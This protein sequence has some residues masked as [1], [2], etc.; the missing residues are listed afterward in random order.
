MRGKN[1]IKKLDYFLVVL[2]VGLVLAVGAIS[3]LADTVNVTVTITEPVTEPVV[4]EVS[5]CGNGVIEAGEE[6]DD[7]NFINDDG[8]SSICTTDEEEAIEEEE[9]IIEEEI[10]EEVVPPIEEVV[11]IY[12]LKLI[13]SSDK[14]TARA[15]GIDKIQ[16]VVNVKDFNNNPVSG[17]RIKLKSNQTQDVIYPN[18]YTSS[19]KGNAFFSITSDTPHTSLVQGYPVNINQ[20]NSNPLHLIFGEEEPILTVLLG[21]RDDPTIKSIT[22]NVVTPLSVAGLLLVS[23][24]ITVSLVSSLASLWYL[25]SHLINLLLQW[26]GLKK[27]EKAW[28]LVYNST[29]KEPVDLA[30]VRLFDT[31]TNKVKQTA[32]TDKNGRFSFQP[33]AGR[34]YINATKP[35]FSFPSKLVKGLSSDSKYTKLYF[36]KNIKVEER[37][38]LNFSIPLDP[39]DAIRMRS[40]FLSRIKSILEK[41]STPILVF[42]IIFAAFALWVT[43]SIFS[44]VILAIYI[45]LLI[46]KQFLLKSPTKPWG[47]VFDLKTRKPVSGVV[48]RV[49]D[50][51]YNKL[52]ETKVTDNKGRFSFLLPKGEYYLT[53]ASH[54]Y[55]FASKKTGIK[56]A[57]AGEPFAVE[58]KKLMKINIPLVRKRT[59]MEKIKVPVKTVAKILKSDS[60]FEYLEMKGKDVTQL[61]KKIT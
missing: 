15:D 49:F 43:L 20:Y 21:I 52:L 35:F 61:F 8:C 58:E 42:G 47:K 19:L 33:E 23:S 53:V 4:I 6:C 50:K 56:H 57:Y 30:I 31:K 17:I 46:L 9:E 18:I 34:Y 12:S 27:R 24:L 32:V 45:V 59:I 29:T 11:I 38:T 37:Q 3:L 10:S 1:I 2:L 22:A 13:L 28:G 25:L 40:T 54:K 14:Q 7:N 51:K 60:I 44:G 55:K 48:I 5:V 26:L 41:L 36:G 39:L 16:I